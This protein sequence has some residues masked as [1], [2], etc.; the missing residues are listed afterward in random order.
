MGEVPRCFV[1]AVP[2]DS[3]VKSMESNMQKVIHYFY[4]D[5]DIWHKGKAL[6]RTVVYQH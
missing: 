1:S 2:R 4:D 6:R 3:A 5:V